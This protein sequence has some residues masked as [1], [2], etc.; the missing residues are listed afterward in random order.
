MRSFLHSIRIT[1]GSSTEYINGEE[2]VIDF[3]NNVNF[4]FADDPVGGKIEVSIGTDG[5]R[6]HIT[7]RGSG[8]L[9]IIPY[10]SN[11]IMV[12]LREVTHDE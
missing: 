8:D 2:K 10:A 12:A 11:V 9:E 1:H 4:H 5:L 7:I 6:P 3:H